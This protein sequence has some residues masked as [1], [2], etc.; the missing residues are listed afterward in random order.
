MADDNILEQV[1]AIFAEYEGRIETRVSKTLDD[2]D[3][4]IKALETENARNA[5]VPKVAWILLIGTMANVGAQL[6]S[7]VV[8]PRPQAVIYAAP[9]SAPQSVSLP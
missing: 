5:W 4:R 9:P 1:R 7:A 2:H 8:A 3:N 6:W